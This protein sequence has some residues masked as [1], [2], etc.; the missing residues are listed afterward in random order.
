MGV[1]VSAPGDHFAAGPYRS[2]ILSGI[3]G[4]RGT[5]RYPTVGVGIVSPAGVKIDH[6]A[7]ENPS[8]DDHLTAGPYGRVL[9]T[10]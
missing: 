6:R 7:A 5:S 3:G 4:I 9:L 2:V 1:V 10:G 8:P